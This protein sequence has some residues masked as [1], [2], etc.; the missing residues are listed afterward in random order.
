MHI[1]KEIKDL[2]LHFRRI[3]DAFVFEVSRPAGVPDCKVNWYPEKLE[4]IYFINNIMTLSDLLEL[5]EEEFSKMDD[6]DIEY[7]YGN[8]T[9]ELVI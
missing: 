8:T 9:I 3:D 4:D 1:L 6:E 7:Y 5:D 2:P